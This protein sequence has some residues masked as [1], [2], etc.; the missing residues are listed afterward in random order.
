MKRSDDSGVT[1]SL[2]Q[3]PVPPVFSHGKPFAGQPAARTAG[4]LVLIVAIAVLVGVAIQQTRSTLPL[5][6]PPPTAVSQK[7]TA[8]GQIRPVAQARVGTIGGG[9]LNRLVVEVGDP[10]NDQQEL[11]RVRG[12]E[13]TEVVTSPLRG[14]VTAVLAHLGDTLGPAATIATVADL[15]RLQVETNDV[16]EFLIAHVRRD[17]PVAVLV[18]ALEQTLQGRVRN[19]SLQPVTT[20]AGDEHYPVSIDLLDAHQSLRAGMSVRLRFSE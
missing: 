13:G 2:Q 14:T 15:S 19:V 5:I 12:L 3:R 17:Q 4:L 10:V 9:V 1:D 8:R 20:P 18:E 6:P 11:A 16:D 7:L